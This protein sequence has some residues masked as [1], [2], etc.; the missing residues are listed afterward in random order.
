MHF[1]CNCLK[2]SIGDFC[3]FCAFSAIFRRIGPKRGFE[4][5]CCI[6]H[7]HNNK[8][9]AHV[10]VRIIELELRAACS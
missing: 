7:V 10:R 4:K 2:I 3:D 8:E 6:T 9:R 1:F 5:S